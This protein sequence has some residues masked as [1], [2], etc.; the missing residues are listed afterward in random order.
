MFQNVIS[1]LEHA[2]Y[3]PIVRKIVKRDNKAILTK[4]QDQVLWHAYALGFFKYPREINTIDLPKKLGIS[5]STFSETYR[6]GI[7]R[8][9]QQHFSRELRKLGT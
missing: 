9:L 2:G 4:R 6:R 3:D 1:E 5:T 7:Q 8:L